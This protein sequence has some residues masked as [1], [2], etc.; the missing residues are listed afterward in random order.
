MKTWLISAFEPF[1]DLSTNSSQTALAHLQSQDWG[2]R[3][4]F[5]ESLPVTFAEAWP[6][7]RAQIRP[8]E[9]ILALGQAESRSRLS[10]ETL[11]LNWADSRHPD[12]AGVIKP[13]GPLHPQATQ[14]QWSD[15][16][17]KD[18]PLTVQVERSYSAGTY[19]CNALYFD[20]LKWAKEQNALA[21][22]VHVPLWREDLRPGLEDILHFLLRL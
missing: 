13:L 4:R 19:V 14:M 8:G 10:L 18:F 1:G 3:V 11:A 5:A 9:N 6:S 22:F 15:I 12:N 21:G 17:W 2:G 16:P 20:L 7:L